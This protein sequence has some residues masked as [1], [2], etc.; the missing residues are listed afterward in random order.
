MTEERVESQGFF[1]M[2]WDCDHCDTKGLLAKSQR[3]CPE[4]GAK[5]NPDKRYFPKEGDPLQRVDGHQ[6]EG[7]DWQCASCN[8]PQ[9]AKANNCSNCGAPKHGAAEVKGIAAPAEPAPKKRP[10][11]RRW[12]PPVA[13]IVVVLG[14]VFGTWYACFRTTDAKLTVTGHAWAC[15]IG[16]EKFGDVQMMDVEF[17][18]ALTAVEPQWVKVTA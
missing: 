3:H 17:D 13:V 4:C 5:Q 14:L 7:S 10:W 2:L 18:Y 16:I 1:E 12:L 9:S 8:A 11:W 15:T 6:Y